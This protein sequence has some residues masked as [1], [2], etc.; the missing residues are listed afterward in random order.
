MFNE[1]ENTDFT[2]YIDY[3][4]VDSGDQSFVIQMRRTKFSGCL[5]GCS[6]LL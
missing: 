1:Q 4:I 5:Y 6:I 3:V 2:H